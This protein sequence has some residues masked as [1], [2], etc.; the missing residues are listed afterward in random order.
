MNDSNIKPMNDEQTRYESKLTNPTQTDETRRAMLRAAGA[1]GLATIEPGMV[2]AKSPPSNNPPLTLEQ[3]IERT[4]FF[5]LLGTFRQFLYVPAEAYGNYSRARDVDPDFLRLK[6]SKSSEDDYRKYFEARPVDPEAFRLRPESEV[7]EDA[8]T[9]VEF[10]IKKV[11]FMRESPY[12]QRMGIP[13]KYVYFNFGSRSLAL[14][15]E[16]PD[17]QPYMGKP[18]IM[19][20]RGTDSFD[21]ADHIPYPYPVH[22]LPA[23]GH[24]LDK[25]PLPLS[26]LTKVTEIAK[27]LGM[28]QVQK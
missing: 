22:F 21:S 8:D 7:A 15:Q 6:K 2:M 18:V 10:E 25:F 1:F 27:R 5:I 17:W 28:R 16:I 23:A 9:F 4:A 14:R 26:D 13:K 20:S 3:R 11:L 12:I 19:F 24:Y